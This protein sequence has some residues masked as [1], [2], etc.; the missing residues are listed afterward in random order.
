[1]V[2]AACS[3]SPCTIKADADR[4]VFIHRLLSKVVGFSERKQTLSKGA[5][6]W[7]TLTLQ[8]SWSSLFLLPLPSPLFF[9]VFFFF[10][11]V[12]LCVV[13]ECQR[14]GRDVQKRLTR[15]SFFASI[16]ASLGEPPLAPACWM[17]LQQDFIL[18]RFLPF[19]FPHTPR[20]RRAV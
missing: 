16:K 11:W 8:N 3:C 14:T 19:C 20:L 10:F 12:C 9:V 2:K 7:S 5:K 4:P 17:W 18:H 15:P 13:L 1:M 6:I